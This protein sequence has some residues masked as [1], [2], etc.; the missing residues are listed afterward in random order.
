[1]TFRTI[2]AA[3]TLVSVRTILASP[4]DVFADGEQFTYRVS[5]AIFPGAG[6]IV[7]SAHD[8]TR[9][10]RPVERI[11]VDTSSHGIVRIFYS[12]NDRAEVVV[13]RATGHIIEAHDK[14]SGGHEPSDTQTTF[15]YATR[16]VHSINR[17]RPDRNRTFSLP[18]GDPID[19]ISCLISTRNWDVKPGDRR[20]ALVYFDN[21]VYPVTIEAEGYE[22]LTTPLGTFKTLRL[23]PRMEH[24]PKGIFARGGA[25]EVWVSQSRPRL[26]VRMQLQLRLGTATLTLIKHDPGRAPP[27]GSA[28]GPGR[29][30]PNT[31]G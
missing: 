14:S 12:Y 25:I 11:D 5:W 10:G 6:R 15:D 8:D 27:P 24:H 29:S 23:V 31:G 30:A 13:D 28:A 4:F 26:P 17:A 19:L 22:T 21:D 1:M 16:T 3:M 9:D 7:I 20:D 18:P 2:V